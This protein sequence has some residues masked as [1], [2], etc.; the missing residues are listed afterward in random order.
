[1]K[2]QIKKLDA[3]AVL[4]VEEVMLLRDIVWAFYRSGKKE[5]VPEYELKRYLELAIKV[6]SIMISQ[7]GRK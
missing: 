7:F 1:M 6:E 5:N 3:F 4:S 2:T